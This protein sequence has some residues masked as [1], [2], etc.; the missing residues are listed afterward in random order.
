[1]NH[2]SL[3]ETLKRALSHQP[4]SPRPSWPAFL[5]EPVS[6]PLDIKDELL[7]QFRVEEGLSHFDQ[8]LFHRG[9]GVFSLVTFEMLAM[10][11]VGK[12][13]KNGPE[14][15]VH[16]LE[17]YMAS[18]FTPGYEILA[19][20]G[21]EITRRHSIIKDIDLIPFSEL[22]LSYEKDILDPQLI[23]DN[24]LLSHGLSP[25]GYGANRP[26]PPKAALIRPIK[27]SPKSFGT[28]NNI[29]ELLR[30]GRQYYQQ[31][32]Q[33][34][35]C[36]TLI[37]PSAPLPRVHWTGVDQNVLCYGWIGRGP[38]APIYGVVPLCP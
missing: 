3:V 25:L 14:E 27:I 9:G 1:M 20:S 10:W 21:V 38:S 24:L 12:A 22:P 11:L 37:G 16:N 33:V 18:P 28:G 6:I 8:R 29:Q 26:V 32:Y 2:T 19:L 36:M 35:E 15:A 7:A 17:R 23:P 30:V 4:Q 34:W 13:L 31:L 5:P